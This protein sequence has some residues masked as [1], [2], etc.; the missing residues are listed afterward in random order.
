MNVIVILLLTCGAAGAGFA[1]GARRRSSRGPSDVPV[2]AVP[3]ERVDAYVSSLSKFSEV[4]TPVWSANVES[5]RTQMEA[6][7]S[8]LVER[9]AGI[10]AHLDL[11]LDASSGS[12]GLEQS[13][14]FASSRTRLDEVV[15]ALNS[16]VEQKQ[17]TLARMRTLMSLNDQMR[18]MTGEV[19][20]I[21]SQTRLLAL[22]T[23]IEAER[24]GEAGR[25]FGVV[26]GEVRSLADL[27]RATGERIRQTVDQ[28]SEAIRSAFEMAEAEAE[29]EEAVVAGA[30]DRVQSV[31]DDLQALVAGLEDSSNTLSYAAQSIKGDIGESIVQF[32]FQDR[33]GQMLS[34]V[35]EAI[36]A[37]PAAVEH[38][39]AGG[40]LGLE[41]IDYQRLLD[42]LTD[43][44]T[45][46]DE[47][48]SPSAGAAP[49]A[50]DEITFF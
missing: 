7:I 33:I 26:A 17:H 38:S 10:A 24:A 23:A 6:A 34:H 50:D 35:S 5:S 43:S 30:N 8:E 32:Q 16:T 18:E 48:H 37:F 45:M 15:R 22:N 4:V 44:Y 40:A 27:S 36:D 49:S 2:A 9:F 25:T 12:V 11:A 13:S 39:L 47:H 20:R 46:V 28:V 3:A 42:E 31:L 19:G 29:L 41:P 1:T 14:V 21:A